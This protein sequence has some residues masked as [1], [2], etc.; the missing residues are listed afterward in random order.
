M[1]IYYCLFLFEKRNT[2]RTPHITGSKKDDNNTEPTIKESVDI[3]LSICHCS[4]FLQYNK[5]KDMY[6]WYTLLVTSM[7]IYRWAITCYKGQQSLMS[8]QHVNKTTSAYW[9]TPLYNKVC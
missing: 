2:Y 6:I 3:G 1:Y 7:F 8:Y 4:I 9:L 5:F